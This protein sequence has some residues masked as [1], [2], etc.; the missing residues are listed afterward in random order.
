[1]K[2]PG[3][4]YSN[5]LRRLGIQPATQGLEYENTVRPVE[6]VAD[7]RHLSEQVLAPQAHAGGLC[8]PDGVTGDIAIQLQA[9]RPVLIDWLHVSYSGTPAVPLLFAWTIR[10]TVAAL[11]IVAPKLEAVPERPTQ[12]VVSFGGRA[13]AD[14]LTGTNS[15]C[16]GV[17]QQNVSNHLTLPAFRLYVPRGRCFYAENAV[18]AVTGF[19]PTFALRF[20]E[21]EA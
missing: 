3:R 12:S 21:F 4:T 11:P 5:L 13:F 15:P 1:M 19:L 20:T 10:D 14:V 6:I 2:A 18:N 7:S 17:F 16:I 9:L 8:A